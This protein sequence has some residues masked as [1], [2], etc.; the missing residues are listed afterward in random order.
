MNNLRKRIKTLEDNNKKL[1][2]MINNILNISIINKY[3]NKKNRKFLD[4]IVNNELDKK[5]IF[6]WINDGNKKFTTKLIYSAIIDGDGSNTI[7]N[8][9]DNVGPTLK[10]LNLLIIEY[11]EVIQKKIGK[12]E[13]NSKNDSTA[14]IFSLDKKIKANCND[15]YCDYSYGPMFGTELYISSDC[16]NNYNSYVIINDDNY[17]EYF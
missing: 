17:N 14:F 6:S 16:L 13:K 12:V 10:L 2:E 3:L 1:K 7:H 4:G 9:C 8:L 5:L 11:L 15:I